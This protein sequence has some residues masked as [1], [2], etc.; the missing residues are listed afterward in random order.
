MDTYF[1]GDLY[2]KII[3]ELPEV[4]GG[5]KHLKLEKSKQELER[6]QSLIPGG[7][8]GSRQPVNFLNGEFPIYIAGGK[9]GHCWDLDGNEFID[10]MAGF[11]PTTLGLAI[12]EIDEAVKAQIDNGFCFTI[13]QKA[14][15]DLAEKMKEIVPC[16]ERSVFCKTGTDATVIAVRIARAYT[17]NEI[18][19]TSGFHGWA[20]FSQYEIDGGV[21][22]C[23]R[24]HTVSI[25]YGDSEGYE[26]EIKKGNIACIMISTV[27]AGPMLPVVCDKAFIKRM[28]E[29]ADEYSVPL[30]FDEIRTGFRYDLDGGMGKL[31]VIPDMACFSKAMGNGYAIAAVCGRE[32][33]MR[34][35]ANVLETGKNATFITS[36]YFTNSLE[37]AAALAVI[38]YYQKNDVINSLQKK[39]RYYNEALAKIIQKHEAPMKIIGDD[40]QPGFMFD[41]ANMDLETFARRTITLSAY[42]IRSG[43]LIHPWRQQ[44]FMYTHTKAD[45]DKS[46]Q[47]LDEG[48]A[49][50]RA[51]YPW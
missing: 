47:M 18:I 22:D 25:P 14:Q 11:G 4:L 44:Y 13:P 23:T 43:I 42:L 3:D 6:A 48:L 12:P 38:D 51:M 32:E 39:G 46:L 41:K 9:N 35:I 27:T 16:A 1:L 45:I 21:L 17:G 29:L 40:G 28:R 37:M 34:P 20:D 31:G 24:D 5:K 26:R 15:N 7:I 2:Q 8:C 33:V 10:F 30:I 36:T 49:V 50:V 19:L